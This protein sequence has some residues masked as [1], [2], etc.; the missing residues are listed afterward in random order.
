MERVLLSMALSS[1][2]I[3]DFPVL[4]THPPPDFR[5]QPHALLPNP[6]SLHP[7]LKQCS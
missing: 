3:S 1:L 4:S 7:T 5:L 2:H 6:L